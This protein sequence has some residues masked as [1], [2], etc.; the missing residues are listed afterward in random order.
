MQLSSADAAT[1]DFPIHGGSRES[2][3]RGLR[4]C[5]SQPE[6]PYPLGRHEQSDLPS[7]RGAT[8]PRR[9]ESPG[10]R[11]QEGAGR[12]V[13]PACQPWTRTRRRAGRLSM[14][15]LLQPSCSAA[16]HAIATVARQSRN[17][18]T[19]GQLVR[20]QRTR[21]PA[22]RRK[23]ESNHGIGSPL[24]PSATDLA[25]RR[26]PLFPKLT[27]LT[28]ATVWLLDRPLRSASAAAP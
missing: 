5:R 25:R 11:G 9:I 12:V 4:H 23:D 6:G 22:L 7:C 1:R 8:S 28:G 2:R 14:W 21:E 16:A 26:R 10:S 18:G 24:E 13:S 3:C 17:A 15:A 27:L 19:A 20:R